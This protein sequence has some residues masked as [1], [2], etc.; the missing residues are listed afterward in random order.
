[1]TVSAGRRCLYRCLR[2]SSQGDVDSQNQSQGPQRHAIS[3][4]ATAA[5]DKAMVYTLLARLGGPKA[6]IPCVKRQDM[7]VYYDAAQMADVSATVQN[8]K[9]S[10]VRLPQP[11][12]EDKVMP[13]HL[14]TYIDQMPAQFQFKGVLIRRD[15]ALPPGP[16]GHM[17]AYTVTNGE[18]TTEAEHAPLFTRTMT[19]MCP[20]GILTPILT[21]GPEG[22]IQLVA[23]CPVTPV[24]RAPGGHV[25]TSI[26]VMNKQGTI[27]V[28]TELP[29]DAQNRQVVVTPAGGDPWQI[30]RRSLARVK[31]DGYGTHPQS[32][33]SPGSSA[34]TMG[35]VASSM[36]GVDCADP[37]R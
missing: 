24:A 31:E 30:E 21:P 20:A 36:D 6:V 9:M 15:K 25:G 7:A 27:M 3:N 17:R 18:V 29:V 14:A 5:A 23:T 35:K 26:Q 32:S 1:M 16:E 12:M 13:A 2:P 11:A 33:A 8:R 19:Y 4:A 28:I 34:P 10:M 37:L 22:A